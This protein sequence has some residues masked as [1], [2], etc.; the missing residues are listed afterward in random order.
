MRKRTKS[1]KADPDNSGLLMGRQ[2]GRPSGIRRSEV[3]NRAEDFGLV[4][5][6]CRHQIKWEK[7]RTAQSEQDLDEA[8]K[9]I[10]PS[11]IESKFRP[12]YSLIL[13]IVK[14]ARLP[15]RDINAQISFLADS[16]G[17]NGVISPRRSRNICVEERKKR[18]HK[19]IRREFYIECTCGYKGPA[20]DSG[21]RDCG[22]G[23]GFM[24][25]GLSLHQGK[26]ILEP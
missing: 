12:R 25:G 1:S 7:L 9:D 22:T 3:V 21:C 4:L 8:F 16:I 19:I 2:P 17:G 24:E 13:E 23:K 20:L 6:L 10:N 18:E 26:H 15:K 14:E 5:E 11:Y